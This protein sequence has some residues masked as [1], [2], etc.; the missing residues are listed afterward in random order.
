MFPAGVHTCIE[1]AWYEHGITG[2]F[3]DPTEESED[4]RGMCI[5][6]NNVLLLLA[7]N[8]MQDSKMY[9]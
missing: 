8:Y 4:D 1:E 3:E 7:H 9:A 5:R 6:N 2:K